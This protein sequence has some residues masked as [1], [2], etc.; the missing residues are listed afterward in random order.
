MVETAAAAETPAAGPRSLKERAQHFYHVH[1]PVLTVLL[2]VAGFLFDTLFVGRIDKIENIIH[3]ATYLTLCAL[4]TSYELRELYGEFSPPARF[5]AVWRYHTGATHFMLGTLL[6]IYTLF[7]FKSASIS[8]SFLFLLFLAGILAVNELKPFENSGT[9]LRMTLFSLCLVSYFGYLVPTLVHRIGA[10]PFLG[11]LLAAAAAVGGLFWWLRPHLAGREQVLWKHLL[12]P[13]FAVELGF[14]ALYFTKIIPPV[15]L[16]ISSI[17]IYHDV[18]AEGDRWALE[19]T[20]PR[21]KFWQ[22]GDQTFLARPGDKIHA[23]VSVFSPTHFSERLQVRWVFD[24]PRSGWKQSDAVPI[25][26]SGGRGE[27]FRAEVIKSHYQPGHWRVRVETS[28]GRELG[29]ID[30]TVVDDPSTEPR[31]LREVL[32]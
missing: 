32:R 11:S 29:R 21:W 28:D 20:R 1:E 27:G 10:L 4:L 3:Q 2:F 22:R 25:A 16:S 18:H 26:I 8:T 5:K 6:N 30:F 19:M 7:Y 31:T 23:F 17:G 24:D 13:F 9:T 12:I 14:A 15:P